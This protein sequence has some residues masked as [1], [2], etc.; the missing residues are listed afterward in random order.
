MIEPTNLSE[1]TIPWMLQTSRR[2]IEYDG[3][4]GIVFDPWSWIRKSPEKRQ[5]LTNHIG[6]LLAMIEHFCVKENVH[7]WL[8]AHPV[9]LTKETDGEYEGLYAPPDLYK[10][11]DSAHWFNTAYMGMTV[12]RNT[13][14]NSPETEVHITKVK[15][16]ENGMTGRIILLYDKYTKR[17]YDAGT[18][19]VR[20]YGY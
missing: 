14:T 1:A 15:F 18:E 12:W 19:P 9:K 11:S 2:A 5:P 6:D 10:I 8:I 4:Q 16:E 20:T 17:Y 7:L 13:V 3:V